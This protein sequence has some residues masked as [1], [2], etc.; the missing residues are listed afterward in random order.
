MTSTSSTRWWD[1]AVV[2]SRSIIS[3]AM[4]TAVSNPKVRSVSPMSLSIVF[5]M[6]TTGTPA[7]DS[8]WAAVSVPSPPIGISTSIP[9]RAS[10]PFICGQ[11]GVQ[12][13]GGD[14][15]RAERRPAA[16]EQTVDGGDVQRGGPV[17]QQP[18]PAVPE[19]D[20]LAAVVAGRRADDGPDDCV[21]AGAVAPAGED[22][23]AHAQL[24]RWS[25]RRPYV[26]TS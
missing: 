5:G 8:R 13:L 21:Q 9:C 6:P 19:A 25:E 24:P 12:A 16:G 11:P 15:G 4:L 20:Y 3:V 2:C 18:A 26:M 14:A 10:T 7:S 23:D 22:T 17:L 1:S